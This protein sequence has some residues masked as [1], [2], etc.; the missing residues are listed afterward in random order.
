MSTESQKTILKADIV[1]DLR[2]NLGLKDGDI[3]G[4]HSSMKSLGVVEG[5]PVTLIKALIEA[6]GGIG[7]GTV[8]M[9]CFNNP[10]DVVDMRTTSCRLGL[11]PETFRKYPGVIR[12]E[13]QTHSVAVIGKYA[14]EIAGTHKGKAPLA[15][16]TPFHEL[17]IR[18]GWIIH[19]GCDM[20]SSSIV[21]VAESI[22]KVPYLHIAYANY[23]KTIKLVVSDDVSY[24]CEPLENPGCSKNFN[25]VQDE[26]NRLGLIK[27]GKV[28]NADSMKILGKDII[29]TTLNLVLSL[30]MGALL[31][32]LPNCSV[33]T[34]KKQFL[35]NLSKRH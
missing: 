35:E 26:L 2:E 23:N 5:G 19:I 30:G 32:D 29:E 21:H 4:V 11:V 3:I 12:S 27:N 9:P 10:D 8:L 6:V 20:K 17:A 33:C 13:N 15:A 24:D 1:R 22:A 28:G 25:I 16:G 31:C 18:G 14:K 7:K 34:M